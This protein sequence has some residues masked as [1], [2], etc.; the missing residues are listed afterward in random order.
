MSDPLPHTIDKRASGVIAESRIRHRATANV[1][2]PAGAD[3]DRPVAAFIRQRSQ[4]RAE[5][6]RDRD[7][8]ARGRSRRADLVTAFRAEQRSFGGVPGGRWS[9]AMRVGLWV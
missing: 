7:R 9:E 8:S 5:T 1:L 2:P 4:L 3:R 6:G